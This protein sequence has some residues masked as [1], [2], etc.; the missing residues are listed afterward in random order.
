MPKIKLL[1]KS[2]EDKRGKI[3]D[4][5]VN[6]PKDH[7]LIVTFKKGSIR[8]NHYHKHTFQYMKK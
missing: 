6:S 1:K 3:L 5:F 4:V 8:G 7:C 2:F